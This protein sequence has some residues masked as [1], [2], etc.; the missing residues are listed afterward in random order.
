MSRKHIE[1]IY[2]DRCGIKY[3]KRPPTYT[4]DFYTMEI[5]WFLYNNGSGSKT[6]RDNRSWKNLDYD[7]CNYCTDFFL[8]WWKAGTS[9]G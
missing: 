4:G 2:C 1:E 5:G 8:K 6:S 3:E 7:M 9:D